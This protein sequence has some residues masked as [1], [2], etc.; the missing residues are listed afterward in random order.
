M[1]APR[2]ETASTG[3]GNIPAL[4]VSELLNLPDS[5]RK[6]LFAVDELQEAEATAVAKKSGRTRGIETIYLNQLSRMGYLTRFKRGKKI[7]YKMARYY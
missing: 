4:P 1:I 7:F 5:I 3:K 6:T 2:T